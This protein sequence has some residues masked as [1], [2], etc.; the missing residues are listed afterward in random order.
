VVLSFLSK[1]VVKIEEERLELPF[2]MREEESEMVD[3]IRALRM[4]GVMMTPGLSK[5]RSEL[6][7]RTEGSPSICSRQVVRL[8]AE[9]GGL[10]NT[11][12][13]QK[14]EV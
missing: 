6:E 5:M 14:E 2:D 4:E 7:L 13:L 11:W 9:W 3:N 10:R 12:V 1:E 8:E